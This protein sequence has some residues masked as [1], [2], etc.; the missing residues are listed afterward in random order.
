MSILLKLVL[1]AF[2]GGIGGFIYYKL[3]G[4]PTGSCP[5]T[6]SPVNST[7]YGIIL[8]VLVAVS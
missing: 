6:K 4:C 8:G 3:V 2:I 5:I 1:G 7:I